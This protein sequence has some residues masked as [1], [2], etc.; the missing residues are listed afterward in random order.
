MQWFDLKNLGAKLERSQEASGAYFLKLS[1]ENTA[2]ASAIIGSA[3]EGWVASEEKPGIEFKNYRDFSK[4]STIVAAL[5]PFFDR[6]QVIMAKVDAGKLR[7]GEELLGFTNPI[8]ADLVQALYPSKDTV[9]QD[10]VRMLDGDKRNKIIA[11]VV[12]AQDIM[13][14]TPS[15][16]PFDG[17]AVEVWHQLALQIGYF[18]ATATMS[19][20][21]LRAKLAGE[22]FRPFQEAVLNAAEIGRGVP[23]LDHRLESDQRAL[24]L[25]EHLQEQYVQFG[26]RDHGWD[27]AY[28]YR[29]FTRA[30]EANF[31]VWDGKALGS[32]QIEPESYSAKFVA[33]P[34]M[35]G[36]WKSGIFMRVSMAMEKAAEMLKIPPR[37]LFAD[38]TIFHLGKRIGADDALGYQ[39]GFRPK[40]AGELVSMRTIKM[41]PS[42]AGVV[43]H[44]MGHAIDLSH[45]HHLKVEDAEAILLDDTGIRQYINWLVDQNAHVSEKHAA[46]LKSPVEMIARSF[47]A[48]MADHMRRSGD[49]DFVSGGGIVALNGGFDH[50]PHS[51]LTERFVAGLAE[52]ISLTR[53]YRFEASEEKRAGASLSM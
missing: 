19:A 53:K 8:G 36:S 46:Y 42:A 32:P 49:S 41:S 18:D 27:E 24:R 34:S 21:I 26:D 38:R 5:E 48:A 20:A 28:F 51:D 9:A 11:R 7:Q 37:D 15:V 47:E 50:A 29:G 4:I 25:A 30:I 13:G 23:H 43:V 2:E 16:V 22:V 14:I 17:R 3:L 12:A 44:E 35:P 45:R 40:V 31:A 6:D 39:R 1:F 33:D 10:L 52:V